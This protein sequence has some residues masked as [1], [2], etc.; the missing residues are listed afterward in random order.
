MSGDIE[1]SEVRGLLSQSYFGNTLAN[2]AIALGTGI[3]VLLVLLALRSFVRSRYAKYARNGER[4][5]LELPFQILSRT[6]ALFL[7]I[8]AIFIGLNALEMPDRARAFVN[9]AL[10]VAIFFQ[11]G[12]WCSASVTVWIDRRRQLSME[13][14]R[15][16]LTS[17]V[18]IGF[19]G[20]LLVWALMLLLALDNL[21]VNITAL[22]AGLGVGG[23]AVALAVQ[24]VLGDLL[25]SLSIALD[26]PFVV[27]DTIT[28]DTLNGTVEQIGLKTTRL[29][30]P[31][32][33]QII[34]SNADLLKSR[35]RNFQSLV[36]RRN[37]FRTGVAYETPRELLQQIPQMIRSAVEKQPLARFDRCHLAK[38]GDSA[39][40]FETVYKVESPEYGKYMDTQ[41]AVY[42]EIHAAFERAG[43]KFAYPTRSIWPASVFVDEAKINA[44]RAASPREA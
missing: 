4:Q 24:N 10:M 39:L 43:I 34:I 16:S 40:E 28:V 23:I 29:R 22:V 36:E 38:F 2:W 30:A 15:A 44:E 42:L 27:G 35:L 14:D 25:A 26:K 21:G 20:Q 1:V 11:L 32:G 18:I 3:A 5:F 31:S 37:E 12:V 7:T 13:R 41:Q 9:S 33:E 8:V 6:T 19:V 17:L